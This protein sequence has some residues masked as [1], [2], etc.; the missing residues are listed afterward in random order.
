MEIQGLAR[1]LGYS[2]VPN[3][4]VFAAREDYLRTYLSS[5]AKKKIRLVS[6]TRISGIAV[7]TY[8]KFGE[9][10]ATAHFLRHDSESGY[11]FK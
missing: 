1:G 2:S 9:G 6:Q 4:I 10:S 5:D 8:S 3:F 7:A 11:K